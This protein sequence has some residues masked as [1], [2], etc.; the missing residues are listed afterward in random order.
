MNITPQEITVVVVSDFEAGEKTWVDEIAMARALA[1]QDFGFNF[2]VIIVENEDN[3]LSTPPIALKEALPLI[4]ILYFGESR[5]A[6]LKDYGVEKTTTP[7]VAVLEADALPDQDWLRSLVELANAHPEAD[8]IS[9]RTYY[10][11]ETMWRRVLNLLDRS[12]DDRGY[13]IETMHI[14][15]NGA[16][17]KTDLLKSFPYPAAATPFSSARTR[18]FQIMNNGARILFT[19]KARMRHAIGGFDFLWDFRRNTG[20]SDMIALEDPS[21]WRIPGLLFRRLKGQIGGAVRVGKY[22]LKPQDWPLWLFLL[23]ITRI[24]EIKGMIEALMH[25]KS[26]PDAE[27]KGSAYR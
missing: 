25:E 26:G 14:S 20:Y 13:R 27:L 9:G 4:E 11:E 19:R 8:I 7:W 16:L 21:A 23:P 15:N 2:K 12:F 18:N 1:Q 22:Y 24:P 10:G 3:R 5:S 17:Y 6:A